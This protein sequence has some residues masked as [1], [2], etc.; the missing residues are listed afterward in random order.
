MDEMKKAGVKMENV[1]L[2]PD[3]LIRRY[4]RTADSIVRQML[5]NG[6]VDMHGSVVV[7]DDG[8]PVE[9]LSKAFEGLDEA[10][11][12]DFVEFLVLQQE[13]S[14]LSKKLADFVPGGQSWPRELDA[15]KAEYRAG[16]ER[17]AELELN[18]KGAGFIGRSGI[19]W[20]WNQG[21][22]VNFFFSQ[23]FIKGRE[24]GIV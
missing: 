7:D 12:K 5:E 8:N 23:Y 22:L 17:L 13:M 11:R 16:L 2:N 6:M 10:Q 3:T 20:K 4:R 14:T 24:V 9:P 21:V 18:A 15:M 19:V 1:E